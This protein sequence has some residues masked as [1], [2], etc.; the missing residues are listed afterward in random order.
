MSSVA[1]RI[2][3]AR[4]AWK[5]IKKKPVFGWGL[6]SFLINRQD[7]DTKPG[8]HVHCEPIEILYELGVVGLI[9]WLAAVGIIMVRGWGSPF[10]PMLLAMLVVS[11]FYF[12]LRRPHTGLMFWI[13][14]G[15]LAR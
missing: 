14:L 12:P 15:L 5:L 1:V 10:M 7:I 4:V 11:L 2:D 3:Q 6:N 9:L 13:T 8:E